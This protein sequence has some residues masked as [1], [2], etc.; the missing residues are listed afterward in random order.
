MNVIPGVLSLLSVLSLPAVLS[1]PRSL[2]SRRRGSGIQGIEDPD[3]LDSRLRGND[4]IPPRATTTDD[5]CR[6]SV[7]T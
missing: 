6:T 3:A 7:R 4:E 2:P 5:R 1:F